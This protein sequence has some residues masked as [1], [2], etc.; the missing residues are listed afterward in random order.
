[1][2]RPGKGSRSP[3]IFISLSVILIVLVSFLALRNVVTGGVEQGE[4]GIRQLAETPML[5]I[6]AAGGRTVAVRNR[7]A[8]DINMSTVAVYA[9]NV[10]T[11]C[12]WQ[13]EVLAAG[14]TTTCELP[15][16]CTGLA[17]RVASAIQQS[18]R[19]G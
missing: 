4:K 5:A 3:E 10:L 14:K 18:V 9:D 16:D 6:E 2:D 15:F 8:S 7:G 19:C 12:A 11:S 1:M 17:I 13:T